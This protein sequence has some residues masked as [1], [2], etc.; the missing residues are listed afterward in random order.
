MLAELSLTF[1]ELK[2]ANFYLRQL[3]RLAGATPEAEWQ[4]LFVEAQIFQYLDQVEEAEQAYKK[5]LSFGVA[6]YK[7]REI[8][9]MRK[10]A[11]LYHYSAYKS[12]LARPLYEAML[13]WNVRNDRHID[14]VNDAHNLAIIS[15]N[16]NDLFFNNFKWFHYGSS[17]PRHKKILSIM[18]PFNGEIINALQ[19]SEIITMLTTKPTMY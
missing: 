15:V 18:L 5:C 19:K 12:D 10:L 4:I 8:A 17:I 14:A 9:C 2:K 13:D 6:A 16:E 11:G 3:K 7:I 1:N